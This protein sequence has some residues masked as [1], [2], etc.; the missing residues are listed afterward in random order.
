MKSIISVLSVLFVLFFIGCSNLEQETSPIAPELQKSS[1]KSETQNGTYKYLQCFN[2]IPVQSFKSS[3]DAGDI[4]SVGTIEIV[5]APENFPKFFKHMFVVLEYNNINRL[6]ANNMLFIDRPKSNVFQLENVVTNE[7]KNV[8]VYAY[9]NDNDINGINPTYDYLTS[10][11][12]MTINNW[13]VSEDGIEIYTDDWNQGLGDT[14][15]EFSVSNA[16]YQSFVLTYIARPTNGKI[17]LP[18]FVKG[19]I[20]Q[21]KMFGFFNYNID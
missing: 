7:L 12:E 20:T 2:L 3:K 9:I 10:F 16:D 1:F 6:A 17:V 15:V 13:N 14:F 19:L 11:G 5:I 8:K 4:K 18:R 21:V